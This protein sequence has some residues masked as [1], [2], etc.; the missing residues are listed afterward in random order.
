[1]KNPSHPHGIRSAARFATEYWPAAD[2]HRQLHRSPHGACNSGHDSGAA[3]SSKGRGD[4]SPL[5]AGAKTNGGPVLAA[6]WPPSSKPPVRP[7][8]D[9]VGGRCLASTPKL[10]N[11]LSTVWPK[12][13]RV[14]QDAPRDNVRSDTHGSRPALR[15]G[16]LSPPCAATGLLAVL[17]RAWG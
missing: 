6:D 5:I 11:R 8:P 3:A 16:V 12:R 15:Q 2:S 17:C 10:G 9:A 14:P 13:S 4:P 7:R 1:M